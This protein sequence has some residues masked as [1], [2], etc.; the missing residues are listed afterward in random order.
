MCAAV[1]RS[2]RPVSSTQSNVRVTAFFHCAYSCA[3]VALSIFGVH[4]ASLP[5][6]ER[7]SS[8]FFQKPTASPAAYA[9]PS[10]VVSATFG[11]ITGTWR[12]SAWNCIS[13]SL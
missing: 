4:S 11:R 5:Q 10:A 8:T 2:P 9:A 7:R 6:L 3:T 1:R 13:R 12:Q